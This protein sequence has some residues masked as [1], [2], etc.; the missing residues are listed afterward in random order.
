MTTTEGPTPPVKRPPRRRQQHRRLS[1]FALGPRG[2]E[3]QL[4]RAWQV[5]C[6]HRLSEFRHHLDQREVPKAPCPECKATC[7][8]VGAVLGEVSVLP[9]LG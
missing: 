5:C 2:G 8:Y 3:A 1:S 9:L 4:W 6:S 7:A